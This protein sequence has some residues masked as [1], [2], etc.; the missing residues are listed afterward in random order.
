[1]YDSMIR[2]ATIYDIFKIA[3]MWAWMQNEMDL[4][5]R[6]ADD[7]EKEKFLYG[8][9]QKIYKPDRVVLVAEEDGKIIGFVMGVARYYEYG[10][11]AL[12]GSCEHLYVYPEHRDKGVAFKLLEVLQNNGRAM[13]CKEIEFITKY[14]E[15][16]IKIYGRKGYKPVEIVFV[17]EV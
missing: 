3:D 10:T 4:P 8:L 2:K 9:T 12:V 16:L 13:G 15:K 5:H 17:K 11:A 1:M 6:Y 14:D 7:A